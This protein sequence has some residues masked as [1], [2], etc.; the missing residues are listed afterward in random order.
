MMLQKYIIKFLDSQITLN[1]KKYE[2][3]N[4]DTLP[5][6]ESEIENISSASQFQARGGS[7]KVTFIKNGKKYTRSIYKTKRGT[8]YVKLNNKEIYVS[9]LSIV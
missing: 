6:P 5:F 9:R 2:N 8:K 1:Y 4:F 7:N 3:W